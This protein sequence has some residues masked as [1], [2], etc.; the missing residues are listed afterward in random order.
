[1]SAGLNEKNVFLIK[2]CVDV[3]MAVRKLSGIRDLC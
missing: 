3:F 2:V 1:M